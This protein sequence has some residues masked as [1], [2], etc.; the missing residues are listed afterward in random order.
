MTFAPKLCEKLSGFDEEERKLMVAAT[1][2]VVVPTLQPHKTKTNKQTKNGRK[3]E[4]WG[5]KES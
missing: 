4:E 2:E 5:E 1:N 3:D